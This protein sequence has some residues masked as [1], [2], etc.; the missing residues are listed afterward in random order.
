MSSAEVSLEEG[1]V[2]SGQELEGGTS[3][4]RQDNLSSRKALCDKG[5][6]CFGSLIPSHAPHSNTG[7]AQCSPTSAM[8]PV[9]GIMKVTPQS[10]SKA[11]HAS[12]GQ[13]CC[14]LPSL[15]SSQHLEK[16]WAPQSWALQRKQGVSSAFTFSLGFLGV[17]LGDLHRHGLYFRILP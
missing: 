12:L 10:V 13:R 17:L 6:N 8:P 9:F 5:I 15:S 3:R 11:C 14:D 7:C 2:R 16:G 1:G 4:Q